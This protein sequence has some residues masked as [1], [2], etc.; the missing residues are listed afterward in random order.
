MERGTTA[1]STDDR[2]KTEATKVITTEAPT[3]VGGSVTVL[4]SKGYRTAR[5]TLVVNEG[6]WYFE[7]VVAHLGDS[8][9]VRVG[10]ST[11]KCELNAPVG[12]DQHGYGYCDV[13]GDKVHHRNREPYG[14][15]YASG[16][17][18]GCYIYVKPAKGATDA[19]AKEF[20]SN[21]RDGVDGGAEVED[22]ITRTCADDSVG[23]A[24][25]ASHDAEEKGEKMSRADRTD[26]DR[27]A[28][29]GAHLEEDR[30][31]V[32]TRQAEVS[33]APG[34]L[35]SSNTAADAAAGDGGCVAFVKNGVFQGVAYHLEP[36]TRSGFSPTVSLFTH[37]K[38]EPAARV[39]FNFGPKFVHALSSDFSLPSPKL[40]LSGSE[41][42]SA[43]WERKDDKPGST[44][45]GTCAVRMNDIS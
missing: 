32:G 24:A 1:P 19:G 20:I 4:S 40:L 11:N 12:F 43:A 18:V 35:S 15:A 39:A 22:C 34:A 41:S 21:T 14:E 30:E 42:S 9:H 2:A 45:E 17:V 10:W 26:D 36:S 31:A 13:S 3:E 29:D 28:H 5:S 25:E 33:D 27:S 8:G 23:N 6:A 7:V 44:E 37:G 38:V 16:D